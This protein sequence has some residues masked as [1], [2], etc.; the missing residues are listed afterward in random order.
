MLL[1]NSGFKVEHWGIIGNSDAWYT[2]AEILIQLVGMQPEHWQ[3][4]KVPEKWE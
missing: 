4:W 2:E 3:V 1:F